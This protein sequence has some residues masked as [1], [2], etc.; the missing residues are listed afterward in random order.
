MEKVFNFSTMAADMKDNSKMMN[1]KET[2]FYILVME[3]N[4][5]A[6]FKKEK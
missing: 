1:L 3:I 6:N 5:L 4:I 2:E